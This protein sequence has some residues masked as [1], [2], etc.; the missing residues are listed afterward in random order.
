MT[1]ARTRLLFVL[2]LV[3]PA[4][5]EPLTTLG[6]T[7]SD[8]GITFYVHAGFAGTAQS[9]NTDVADLGKVEGPC[10]K[11]EEGEKPTWSDCISSLHVVS[12]WT[13]TL[14]EDKDYHGRSVTLTADAP[15]LSVLPGPCDRGFNDC[16]SSLK[17]S[18]Q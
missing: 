18:R 4:C 3:M 9:V 2:A 16:V 12:G 14:Y 15:D 13:A 10:S 8:Q 7:P 6:P 5:T 17:V 1:A 11:G